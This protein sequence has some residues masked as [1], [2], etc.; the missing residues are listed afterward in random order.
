ML[1]IVI[2]ASSLQ[3]FTRN[4]AMNTRTITVR[5]KNLL[6]LSL[7]L[8]LVACDDDPDNCAG[9]NGRIPCVADIP[10]QDQPPKAPWVDYICDWT[11]TWALPTQRANPDDQSSTPLDPNDIQTFRIYAA[12]TSNRDAPIEFVMDVN[13]F[14]LQWTFTGLEERRWWFT[15]TVIDTIGRESFMAAAGINHISNTECI[16]N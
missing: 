9:I 2:I 3:G 14:L 16:P 1:V 12:H 5:N 7:L 10:P 6:L 8:T 15:G 13:P 4:D 11:L